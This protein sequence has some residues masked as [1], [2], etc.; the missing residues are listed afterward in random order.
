MIVKQNFVNFLYLCSY[1]LRYHTYKFPLS[2]V[3]GH[4]S[5]VLKTNDQPST[6]FLTTAQRFPSLNPSLGINT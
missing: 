6:A 3:I 4:W 2:L 5:F 1:I